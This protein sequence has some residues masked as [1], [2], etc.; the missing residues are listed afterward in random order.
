MKKVLLAAIVAVGLGSVAACNRDTTPSSPNRANPGDR[1][2]GQPRAQNTSP[3][4]A[5]GS[6][7]GNQSGA[8]QS[9]TSPSASGPQSSSPSASSG[10]Q[11]SSDS[12]APGASNTSP[13]PGQ[14]TE[15][16]VAQLSFESVD[17][18]RDGVI[19]QNEALAVSGFD[20]AAADKDGNHTVSRQEFDAAMANK[21]PGG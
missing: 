8:S 19:T 17:T 5:A 14:G 20:F 2:G 3:S 10:Q 15:S 11:S 21:R 18:N 1:S 13:R 12:G 4:S 6:Q 16:Q 9:T 7:A